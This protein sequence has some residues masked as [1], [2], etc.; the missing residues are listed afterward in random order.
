MWD[1]LCHINPG[2]FSNV[3]GP[4]AGVEEG[5][6]DGFGVHPAVGEESDDHRM[7]VVEAR[8]FVDCSRNGE[9]GD[10]WGNGLG[11]ELDHDVEAEEWWC[12]A[13]LV[14]VCGQDNLQCASSAWLRRDGAEVPVEED[15]RLFLGIAGE[16]VTDERFVTVPLVW[17]TMTV[18]R[19]PLWSGS[20][21]R[22]DAH[23]ATI[24]LTH[25]ARVLADHAGEF[26]RRVSVLPE[27]TKQ[28]LVLASAEPG[29]GGERR[30][31]EG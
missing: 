5:V 30:L 13:T 14:G 8:D 26:I 16:C 25:P 2:V 1:V 17:K 24:D 22:S 3:L 21:E 10:L 7:G 11:T 15:G 27:D 4:E 29:P 6:E 23:G 9:T 12:D 19:P 20:S 31:V 18:G 28:L